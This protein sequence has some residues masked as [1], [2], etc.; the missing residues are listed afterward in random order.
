MSS[1]SYTASLRSARSSAYSPAQ[2]DTDESD[3]S[4]INSEKGRLRHR[5]NLPS[6]NTTAAKSS[7][8]HGITAVKTPTGKQIGS[9]F[10]GKSQDNILAGL[11]QFLFFPFFLSF[12]KPSKKEDEESLSSTA[13]RQ[14]ML[15]FLPGLAEATKSFRK[16]VNRF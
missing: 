9:Q 13:L 8:R 16:I 5:I 3:R 12:P 11:V 1:S 10:L 6:F 15:Q 4:T 14:H 7:N 2:W